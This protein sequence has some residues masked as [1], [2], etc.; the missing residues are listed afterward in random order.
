[1]SVRRVQYNTGP[2]IVDLVNV[3]PG[4]DFGFNMTL[5]HDIT[6]SIFDGA[7]YTGRDVFVT[8]ITFSG[9][10][11]LASGAVAVSIPAS[12]TT[13]LVDGCTWYVDETY[14]GLH[15]TLLAGDVGLYHK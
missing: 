9:V 2:A 11:P 1:M 5:D 13:L 10:A 15:R 4:D 14:N 8:A 3:V 12:G 6:T 7:V